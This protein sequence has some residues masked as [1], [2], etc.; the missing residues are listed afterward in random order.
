MLLGDFSNV[1]FFSDFTILISTG[2]KLIKD[3][4]TNKCTQDMK[5]WGVA[6]DATGDGIVGT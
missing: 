2:M 3:P 4:Y 5:G 6:F 1:K